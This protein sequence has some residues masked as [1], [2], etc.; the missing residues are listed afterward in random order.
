M[1]E[2]E[3][4]RW[5]VYSTRMKPARGQ[6]QDPVKLLWRRLLFIIG[7][8][9]VIIL[10]VSVKIVYQKEQDALKLQIESERQLA[11]LQA[12]YSVISE[13]V[14][15]LKTDSGKEEALRTAFNVGKPGEKEV[16]IV[17][18][19]IKLSTSSVPTKTFWQSMWEWL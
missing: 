4:H 1:V 14:D 12:R 18:E 11:D 5:I 7:T 8:V 3:A 16:V 2:K 6:T 13:N 10:G 15:H 19:Q 17:E 9:I